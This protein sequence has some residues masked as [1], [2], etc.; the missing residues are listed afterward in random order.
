[1]MRPWRTISLCPPAT[2][3][4]APTSTFLHHRMEFPCNIDMQ[5]HDAATSK[6]ASNPSGAPASEPTT[7]AHSQTHPSPCSTPT[8]GPCIHHSQTNASHII[9]TNTSHHHSHQ[10]NN[11][12]TCTPTNNATN[13][14]PTTQTQPGP[15]STLCAQHTSNPMMTNVMTSAH[16]YPTHLSPDRNHCNCM[17]PALLPSWPTHCSM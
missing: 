8:A 13:C 6:L 9:P 14:K 12:P 3:H 4:A 2:A 16:Q 5:P 15:G 17:P 1:M 11:T 7:I 10:T